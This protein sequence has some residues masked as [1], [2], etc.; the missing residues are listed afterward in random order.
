[1]VEFACPVLVVLLEGGAVPEP[2]EFDEPPDEWWVPF[3][4]G[5]RDVPFVGGIVE[6]PVIGGGSN[7][8][9]EGGKV[10]FRATRPPPMKAGRGR[11]TA[12]PARETAA[13]GKRTERNNMFINS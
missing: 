2:V 6:L 8:P 7:V 4:G 1:M 11:A 5:A 3:I 12:L 13:R 9:F 10:E